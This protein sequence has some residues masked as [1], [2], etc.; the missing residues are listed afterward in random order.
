MNTAKSL[1]A[2]DKTAISFKMNAE[3]LKTAKTSARVSSDKVVGG[4]AGFAIRN[5]AFGS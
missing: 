4:Q 5:H 1:R 2:S 3:Q